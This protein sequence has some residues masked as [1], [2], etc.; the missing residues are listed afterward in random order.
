MTESDKKRVWIAAG[1]LI[2]FTVFIILI[3]VFSQG[4]P[5]TAVA[6]N[7]A[8]PISAGDHAVGSKDAKVTL[9][10][11]GDFQCPACGQYEPIVDQIRTEYAG[12][13]LLVFRNFPLYQIHQNAGIA[14]QAAEAAA[15]QG[16]YWEMHD[17]LYEKQNDWS[18]VSPADVVKTRFEAYAKTLGLDIAKFNADINSDAVKNKITADVSTGNDAKV[19]HT[20]TFFINLKEIKNPNNYAEFKS[21]LDAAL[22]TTTV[23]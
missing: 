6:D 12:S 7:T 13:V 22:A 14:A 10:E 15:L 18:N 20:P 4:Q 9:I 21:A 16:K 2:V 19:N 8:A 23:Q 11:Y 17:L 5:V 3:A 1:C